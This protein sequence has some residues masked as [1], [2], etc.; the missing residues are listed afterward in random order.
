P[1]EIRGV[2]QRGKT[3]RRGVRRVVLW[4]K[5]RGCQ[6]K[7]AAPMNRIQAAEARFSRLLRCAQLGTLEKRVDL[8]RFFQEASKAL[9]QRIRRGCRARGEDAFRE[10]GKFKVARER[11]C[12]RGT[13]PTA[14]QFDVMMRGP[15]FDSDLLTEMP[16]LT[17]VA[18]GAGQPYPISFPAAVGLSIG[19]IDEHAGE[20]NRETIG[21]LR[22]AGIGK[23][24]HPFEMIGSSEELLARSLFQCQE[25]GIGEEYGALA[26]AIPLLCRASIPALIKRGRSPVGS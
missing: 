23:K 13:E 15:A 8:G 14:E 2:P 4:L 18:S 6:E 25:P 19:E 3:D 7:I 22:P 9:S 1:V 12:E 11:R 26:E 17:G 24:A 21:T 16:Q 5:Q 10:T 20:T